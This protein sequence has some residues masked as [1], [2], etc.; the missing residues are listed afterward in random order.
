MSADSI[1]R[2]CTA[3]RSRRPNAGRGDVCLNRYLRKHAKL[4]S[5]PEPR[6]RATRSAWPAPRGCIDNKRP[7]LATITPTRAAP[8]SP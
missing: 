4:G 2:P 6:R 1:L 3:D 5:A 8:K 7:T